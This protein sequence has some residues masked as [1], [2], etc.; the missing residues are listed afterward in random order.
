MAQ[1]V[2]RMCMCVS[3]ATRCRWNS[4]ES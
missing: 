4:I 3:G 2:T 1:H